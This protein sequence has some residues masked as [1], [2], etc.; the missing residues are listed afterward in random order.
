M[1]LDPATATAATGPGWAICLGDCLD[2]ERGIG[3]LSSWDHLITD[4]PYVKDL[5]RRT[6]TNS[7]RRTAKAIAQDSERIGG[8]EK[9]LTRV[10]ACAA[11]RTRR[12]ALVFSDAE[13]THLWREGLEFGGR[14]LEYIRTGYWVK[15]D[16]M[17]QLTGD[18]PAQSV[19]TFTTC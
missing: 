19:E 16:A 6:R 3:M 14:S 1:S 9:I 15:P 12:W 8:L 17:P 10:A 4:P 5:L 13:S 2:P 18:R 7:K 11:I